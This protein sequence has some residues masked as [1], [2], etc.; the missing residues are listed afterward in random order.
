MKMAM[1]VAKLWVIHALSLSLSLYIY[2]YI[3]IYNQIIA[4]F[5]GLLYGVFIIRSLY[6][7][8][9]Y[10]D[11]RKTEVKSVC[12][13]AAVAW[14]IISWRSPEGTGENTKILGQ[15]CRRPS[16]NSKQIPPEQV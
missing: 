14:Q 6:T 3:Y 5:C 8:E 4:H 15:D 2:I 9:R 7:V 1:V 12:K 16:P 11:R 10:N 13:E